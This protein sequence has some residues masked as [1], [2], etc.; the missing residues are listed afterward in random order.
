MFNIP[1]DQLLPWLQSNCG[2]GVAA[3]LV[4]YP[5]LGYANHVTHELKALRAGVQTAAPVK[6]ERVAPCH[7]NSGL[8]PPPPPLAQ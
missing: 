6:T 3:L 2:L 7:Y 8:V 5:V 4:A 1:M